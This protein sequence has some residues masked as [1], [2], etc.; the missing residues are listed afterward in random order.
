L[1]VGGLL[2]A[3]MLVAA[4]SPMVYL[5][6]AHVSLRLMLLLVV[7]AC[8][9]LSYAFA[10]ECFTALDENGWWALIPAGAAAGVLAGGGA[11]QNGTFIVIA[12]VFVTVPTA[13]ELA[14]AMAAG[15]IVA[16]GYLL[17]IA[18]RGQPLLV[19]GSMGDVAA[20]LSFL[21]AIYGSH[22]VSRLV[23]VLIY[24][25]NHNHLAA[26]LLEA[27]LAQ[28][29]SVTYGSDTTRADTKRAV[30]VA[31]ALDPDP[32]SETTRFSDLGLNDGQRAAAVL[33]GQ[34]LTRKEIAERLSV[35]PKMVSDHREVLMSRLDVRTT[36]GL[37]GK[38]AEMLALPPQPPRGSSGS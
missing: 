29:V 14:P 34:G 24:D 13:A 35:S 6:D 10:E 33:F 5:I 1:F 11:R 37:V 25:L 15:G 26:T 22:R 4:A 17:G 28:R 23:A 7:G 3:V 20:L 27:E 21:V 38:L 18:V 12:A 9:T 16:F 19:N 36:A 32:D 8:V 30:A 31:A 2:F